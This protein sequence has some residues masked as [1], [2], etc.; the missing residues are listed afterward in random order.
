MTTQIPTKPNLPLDIADLTALAN[1]FFHALPGESVDLALPV[2]TQAAQAAQLSVPST[3][4]LATQVPAQKHQAQLPVEPF[5][6]YGD[7]SPQAFGLPTEA[8][9]RALLMDGP[10]YGQGLIAPAASAPVSSSAVHLPRASQD[11]FLHPSARPQHTPGNYYFLSESGPWSRP[12]EHTT[13]VK[14]QLD[15]NAIRKDFPIL[16]E[17]V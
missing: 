11:P 7:I 14:T 15:V 8:Q 17:R 10:Q 3:A 4:Q 5:S 13:P 12:Q 2:N 6:F 16:A 1:A 9:L